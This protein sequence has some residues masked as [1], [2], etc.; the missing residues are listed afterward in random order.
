MVLDGK[1]ESQVHIIAISHTK[2]G[3]A[4]YVAEAGGG[5]TSVIPLSYTFS[6]YYNWE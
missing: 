1:V 4:V 3:T 5:Q 6:K 2:V